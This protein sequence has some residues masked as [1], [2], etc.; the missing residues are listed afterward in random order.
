MRIYLEIDRAKPE[1][2]RP[3]FL[4]PV[5]D[6]QNLE[7]LACCVSVADKVCTDVFEEG[8]F[9]LRHTLAGWGNMKDP[10]TGDNLDYNAGILEDFLSDAEVTE[11]IRKIPVPAWYKSIPNRTG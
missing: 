8:L 2:E 4:F 6:K 1:A 5:M 9:I 11:L 3:Y 7:N 10:V